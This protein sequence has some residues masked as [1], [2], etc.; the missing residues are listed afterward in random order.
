MLDLGSGSSEA[1]PGITAVPTARAPAAWYVDSGALGLSSVRRPADWPDYENYI[2]WQLV[3]SPAYEDWFNWYPD[4]PTAIRATDFHGIFDYGDVPLDYEGYGLAP[5]NLKYNMDWGMWA[6]WARGA[7]AAWVTFADPASRHLADVDILHSHHTPRHWSDGILF[8]H[9][10]HDEPGFT[11]PHRNEGMGGTDL[12]AGVPGMLLGWFI[13]GHPRL[14][15]SARELADC[16]EWR[17]HNDSRL[18]EYFEESN[19]EG[20]ALAE[21]IPGAYG[22]NSR[23]AASSLNVLTEAFRATA[24]PRYLQAADALAQ[25]AEAGRQPYIDG[26][27]GG[28][29]EDDFI[30]PQFLNLLCSAL[31]KYVEVRAEYGLGDPYGAGASV[32]AY[33]EFMGEHVLIDLSEIDT[34]PRA[35][36]PYQWFFDGR[37]DVP[38]E[39]NDNHDPVVTNWMLLGADAMA[40][41]YRF[42]KRDEFMG[43]A[44]RLFRTGARDPF[45]EGDANSYTATKELVNGIVFGHVF[46]HEH[47]GGGG[48][49]PEL[50]DLIF[51]HHSCG[52]NWLDSGLR[53]ALQGKDYVDEV[54]EIT[55]G[56][57]LAPGT[58]RPASLGETPGDL[59]D[60][61]HWILWFNDYVDG[62]RSHGCEDGFNRI[63]L[64][65]SCFP[66][67]HVDTEDS[68][69]ADPFLDVRSPENYRAVY[70]HPDGPGQTYVHGG[71]SYRPLE[72]VF[73]AHPDTLFV[74][75]TAPPLQFA[76]ED[77]TNDESAHRVHEFNAWLRDTWLPAYRTANPNLNNVAVFD[78]FDLLAYAD[79]HAE[80]PNRLREEFGGASGDSHPNTAANETSTAVFATDPDSFLDQAWT[81]F[82]DEPLPD[83]TPPEI[84]NLTVSPSPTAESPQLTAT[85]RDEASALTTAEFF[86]DVDPG[87]G[88]GT[89]IPA[90]DGAFD[91]T[92]EE[93]AAT[94]PVAELADGSHQVHVRA[95][96][97]A[98][99]WTAPTASQSFRIERPGADDEDQDGLP[100][101][102][103]LQHFGGLDQTAHGDFDHDGYTNLQEFESGTDPARYAVTLH[104]GWNN[105]SLGRLPA[106]P[107]IAAVLGDAVVPHG[108]LWAEDLYRLT[109][110]LYPDRG[111]WLY[112]HDQTTIEVQITLTP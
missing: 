36:Y 20:Y 40:Y 11:N 85:A 23:P 112:R 14:L 3:R 96:D 92:Q 70:R 47:T 50:N 69:N 49:K 58:D 21:Y 18:Q 100:D 41:A 106:E 107:G 59:T 65:K 80:H 84:L 9:S 5:M 17:V 38:G 33:Q 37:T 101:S 61:H 62:V 44:E 42:S 98:G 34:G 16:I 72:D 1:G 77:G 60:M 10:Y 95:R 24:D 29:A 12:V 6:Q 99:N 68:G 32:V 83:T 53:A 71:E 73:A 57:T 104:P 22:N 46:L 35:A 111:V 63:V 30:K 39:D 51:I 8:S 15:R 31:G 13:T 76:P 79:D 4:L 54:N 52:Q 67:S 108:W 78:W 48:A 109:D 45:F 89:P 56:T 97:E 2:D 102:W 82:V 25:W 94:I 75:I 28:T 19:G 103:E 88:A 55:Y 27:T 43:C 81:A 74:P 26:P 64:F 87:T 66:N 90:A 110:R 93:L 7:A 91:S 105:L 86:V